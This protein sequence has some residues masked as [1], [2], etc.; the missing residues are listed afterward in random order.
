VFFAGVFY[1]E[2]LFNHAAISLAKKILKGH[3][4]RTKIIDGLRINN[5]AEA[6]DLARKTMYIFR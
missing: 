3:S 1:A 5:I 4:C 6:I 2:C